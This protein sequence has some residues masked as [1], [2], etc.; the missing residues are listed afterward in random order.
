[1]IKIAVHELVDDKILSCRLEV[2]DRLDDMGAQLNGE[3]KQLRGE[4]HQ[5]T[6]NMNKMTEYLRTIAETMTRLAD[7]PDTW[8]KIKGFWAV[9]TWFK[10][11]WIL[12]V[13]VFALFLVTMWGTLNAVGVH[14]PFGSPPH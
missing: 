6:N 14:I 4:M 10:D 1:M 5:I 9:M 12:V 3:I 7:L 8:N 13:A 11:N 2:N